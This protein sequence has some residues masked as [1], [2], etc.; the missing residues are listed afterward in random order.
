ANHFLF[1]IAKQALSL[2]VP[3]RDKSVQ[4]FADNRLVRRFHNGGETA[5][6]LRRLL[7]IVNV[8]TTSDV[9]FEGSIWTMTW[10]SVIQNPAI[11]AS[12]MAEAIFH[13]E[14]L[15]S[16]KAGHVNL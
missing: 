11:L 5:A 12:V 7:L 16:I 10:Y 2:P 6:G 4:V 3:T 14:R 8:E 13:L 15:P 9:A 1:C